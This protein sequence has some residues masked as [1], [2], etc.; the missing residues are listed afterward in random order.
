MPI[1][2]KPA[3]ADQTFNFVLVDPTTGAAETDLVITDLDVTY[4]RARSAAVK[5]D[6]TALS[7]V[8][9][10]HGDNKAIQIDKTNCPGLY[11]VDFPDAAFLANA[12]TVDLGVKGAAIAPATLMVILDTDIAVLSD[13]YSDTTIIASD[14]V[15]VVSDTTAM[16]TQPK[17]IASDLVQ[18]YS[19]TTIVVSD[20][21]AVHTQTTA[22]NSDTVILTADTTVIKSD[23]TAIHTQTTAVNSDT[24]I[25]TS[26]TAV[27]ETKA[28]AA[29]SDTTLIT[30]DTT[31]IKSDTTAMHTQTTTI[32]S[33]LV[34]AV[35]DTT[36]IHTQTTTIASDA[37]LIYSD[38]TLLVPAVSD[39][40]S[41]M[42]VLK[43]DIDSDMVVEAAAHTKT[44]SD[45]A[46]VYSDTAIAVSDTTAIHTQTTAINSDTVILTSD[47]TAMHTQT[48]TIASD[49]VKVYS[50]TTVIASD[51]GAL[52]GGIGTRSVVITVKDT[53]TSGAVIS[54]VRIEVW[55]S[56]GSATHYATDLA[57]NASGQ[58]GALNLDDGTYTVKGWKVGSYT[59]ANATITV[60]SSATTF[61]FY[62][63]PVTSPT[64]GTATTSSLYG[65]MKTA[66]GDPAVGVVIT[67]E[68][69]TLPALTSTTLICT[70]LTTTATTDANGYFALTVIRD[71]PIKITCTAAHFEEMRVTA[72]AAS[73]DLGTLVVEA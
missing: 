22:I 25:L 15:I 7:S 31:I 59:F 73:V 63:V 19:D 65:Y 34:I 45:V 27:I 72:T 6:L 57:T 66:S 69:A 20:T 53:N 14:V 2:V 24:V 36:A 52:A 62:G 5:A 13:V 48:T 21:T 8:S 40:R 38:T 30:A 28:T 35:S 46:L 64:A 54:G 17:T 56:T 60:T 41:A 29:Y 12:A 26:D 11:R 71:K 39:V 61:E 68:V 18:I 23:T 1:K 3:S 70:N 42:V 43:S 44:Q 9:V 50:D 47:T 58:T 55:D 4:V 67:A 51:V 33:D 49:L 16:H 32:A 10:A 37:V